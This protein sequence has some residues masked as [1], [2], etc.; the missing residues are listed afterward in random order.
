MIQLGANFD[1]ELRYTLLKLINNDANI[2]KIGSNLIEQIKNQDLKKEISN[3]PEN[4]INNF[5]DFLR[6]EQDYLIDQIELD[7]GIAK[8][9]LLKE[10]IF[11][12]FLSVI[13]NIPLIMIGKPGSD[14]SLR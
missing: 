6:I 4:K 14:I 12:L 11:L 8:N 10:N 5:S 2:D 1:F 7:K 13:T 3:R 9:G